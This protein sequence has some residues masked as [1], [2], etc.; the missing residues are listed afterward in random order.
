LRFLGID[1]TENLKWNNHI[2]SLCSKLSKTSYIVQSLKGDL[3]P[4]MLRSIYFGKFQSLL[5]CGIIF[6]GGDSDSIKAFR[7][8]K[9]VLRL[10][11]GVG[12]RESGREIFKDYRILTVTVLYILEML[13]YIKKYKA[14]LTQ[15]LDIHRS[16]IR[17]KLDFHV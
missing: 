17:R 9:G 2:W 13:W 5:R 10:I 7:M 16:N 11:S 14:D 15:N 3:S 12:K 4:N 1:I 8:Q 6:W